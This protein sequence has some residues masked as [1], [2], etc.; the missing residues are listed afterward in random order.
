MAAAARNVPP[1]IWHYVPTDENPADCA[2]KGVSAQELLEHHLWWGGPPWILQEPVAVPPQ[3][4]AAEIAR[5]QEVEAKPAAVFSYTSM[6]DTGWEKRYNSYKKL[7][8]VTAYMMRFC[9][10]LKLT[11]QGQPIKNEKHLSVTEVKAAEL[12]LFKRA[13]ARTYS[14]EL[15]RLSAEDPTPMGKGSSLRLVHP[16]INKNGLLAV[17][18][19]LQKSNLTFLQK[20]PIIMSPSDIVT[21]LYFV[22]HHIILSHSGP[23]LLLAHTGQEVYV[24]GAKRLARTICQNCLICRKAAPR[25]YQQKMGQLP[26]PRVTKVLPFVHTGVDFAG[27]FILRYGNP[28]KPDTC[29][30]Y[31]CIFVCLTTK[32]VHIEVVSSVLSSQPSKDSAAEL[33]SPITFTLTMAPILLEPEM[34]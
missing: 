33:A 14:T 3:P 19:R 27:P 30:A 10:T 5:N 22:Y 16:Y 20:N 13:Q 23:T 29:K 31:L 7:L 17:G 34:R 32:L 15:K 24:P 12:L 2:S 18:G 6:T 11:I 8:H 1:S 25:P 28:R 26:A 21:K 4:G 9:L